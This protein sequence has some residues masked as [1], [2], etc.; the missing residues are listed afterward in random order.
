MKDV[1]EE[2]EAEDAGRKEA[3]FTLP[4]ECWDP[5]L[6]FRGNEGGNFTPVLIRLW[7]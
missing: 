3:P 1:G 7:R 4:F 6:N 5:A 2:E